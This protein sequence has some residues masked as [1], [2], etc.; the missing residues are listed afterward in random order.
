MLPMYYD[1]LLERRLIQDVKKGTPM[2]WG[3]V[4]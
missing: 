4:G 2:V 1:M 3:L